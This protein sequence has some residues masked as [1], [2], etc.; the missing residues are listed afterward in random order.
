LDY[1]TST[2]KSLDAFAEEDAPFAAHLQTPLYMLMAE[3]TYPDIVATAALLPLR[4]E[5]PEP[6]TKHLSTLAAVPGE[7]GAW[8]GRLLQNLAR[9]DVRLEAGDFPPTPG[10][11]CS[12]CEL[13]ALC[14]RPVDVTVDSDEEGD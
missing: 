14:G 9:F 10:E 5:A 13:S 4:E 12:W 8:R 6:F 7:P 11:H 3:A 2:K 1:K